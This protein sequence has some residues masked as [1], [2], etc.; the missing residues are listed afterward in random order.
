MYA[1]PINADLGLRFHA[2]EVKPRK[3]SAI[4]MTGA[5]NLE[6]GDIGSMN[7]RSLVIMEREEPKISTAS[8]SSSESNEPTEEERQ[9]LRKI[10]DVL[11]WS[12]F[13]V[14]VIE[15]CERFTYYGL[16]GPFQNYIENSYH[17]PSGLPG[18]IGEEPKSRFLL[19]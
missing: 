13:S 3:M 15:L 2:T 1:W 9:T 14:A 6:S 10:A 5:T 8:L 16:S 17:D 4:D 11:P 18:A 12:A 7:S 19:S